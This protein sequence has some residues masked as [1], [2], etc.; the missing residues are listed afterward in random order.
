MGAKLGEART[1][2]QVAEQACI[3]ARRAAGEASSACEDVR[4][5]LHMA[6][7]ELQAAE[8]AAEKVREVGCVI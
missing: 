3:A 2:A 8:R 6:Q 1:E 5:Q 7:A 4:H